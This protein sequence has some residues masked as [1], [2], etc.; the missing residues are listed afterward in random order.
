VAVTGCSDNSQHVVGLNSYSSDFVQF[1]T[2][3]AVT[4]DNV[5]NDAFM[6]IYDSKAGWATIDDC[7]EFP[8]TAPNNIVVHFT[9]ITCSGSA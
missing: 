9:A 6:Y 1:S 4:I 3:S 2:F 7:G 5:H 8:C